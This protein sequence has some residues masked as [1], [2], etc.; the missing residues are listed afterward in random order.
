MGNDFQALLTNDREFRH[1]FINSTDQVLAEMGITEFQGQTLTVHENS[2][3]EMHFLLLPKGTDLTFCPD[4][5]FVK[6]QERFWEDP[7]F[8]ARLLEDSTETVKEIFKLPKGLKICFHQN[9]AEETHLILP[10]LNRHSDELSDED[11]EMVAGGK[12][13]EVQAIA[14]IGCDIGKAAVEYCVEGVNRELAVAKYMIDET[15]KNPLPVLAA[16][17]T[18]ALNL[19]PVLFI[20]W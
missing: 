1:R 17:G 11:L 16:A 2:P 7:A 4:P 12:G 8:A 13:E 15:I 14:A 5:R 10:V 3:T 6:V 19:A 9:S 20:G 18:I